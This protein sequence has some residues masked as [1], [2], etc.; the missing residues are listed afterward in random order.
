VLL[1]VGM[2]AFYKKVKEPCNFPPT[3]EFP[4]VYNVTKQ[5]DN[6][7]MYQVSQGQ[8]D[9]L[10]VLYDR[11]QSQLYGFF[12]GMTQ[13]QELA[14]DLVQNVFYRLLKYRQQFR[15][16]TFKTW[17]FHI[18]RNVL[19]DQYK[20][21]R[22]VHLAIDEYADK[23]SDHQAHDQELHQREDIQQLNRAMA[24]LPDDKREILL[25][26]KY[27]EKNYK[28][29]GELLGCTEGNVKIKVFRALNELRS[30]YHQV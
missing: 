25:L 4:L 30:L 18:A 19:N 1:E 9:S 10:G 14:G 26:S 8:L 7:L 2:A 3:G 16:G 22:A 15:G 6:D 5:T 21:K 20:R 17:M 28:E 24:A 11:Y 29:I 13:D 27:Q 23:I 12:N